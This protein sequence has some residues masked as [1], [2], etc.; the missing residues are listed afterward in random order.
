MEVRLIFFNEIQNN[1][2]WIWYYRERYS[3]LER[4]VFSIAQSI[5]RKG[6][7]YI[8][9]DKAVIFKIGKIGYAKLKRSNNEI[10]LP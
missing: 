5:V 8:I 6:L 3:A 9:M 7:Y 1:Y 10:G 4:V 2:L